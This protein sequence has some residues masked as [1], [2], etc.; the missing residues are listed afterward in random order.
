HD[1]G[2]EFYVLDGVF[3]D[4]HASYPAGTYVRNPP[5]TAHVPRSDEGCTIF[6]KLRQ[7]VPNDRVQFAIDTTRRS[8]DRANGII[9]VRCLHRFAAEEVLLVDG[10]AM[11]DVSF[12]A[13]A[14]PR[15]CFVIDGTIDV[16]ETRLTRFGWMRLPA[17][18]ALDV[19]FVTAGRILVKTRPILE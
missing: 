14:V 18:R 11:R 5:G 16:G 12:A 4:E 13:A 10:A 3:A 7:F 15:E 19:R 9:E 8:A 1:H 6:V 2:E 17:G